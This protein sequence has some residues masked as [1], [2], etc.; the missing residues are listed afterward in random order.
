MQHQLQNQLRHLRAHQIIHSQQ[1]QIHHLLVV[2]CQDHRGLEIIHLVLAAADHV[3]RQDQFVLVKAEEH[4][5]NYNLDNVHQC[6]VH[7]LVLFVQVLLHVLRK[8]IHVL[9]LVHQVQHVLVVHHLLI[10]HHQH[11]LPA[12]HLV[13]KVA[14]VHHNAVAQLAHLV[15]VAKEKVRAADKRVK[16]KDVK[17]LKIY[18]HHN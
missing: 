18:Q 7:V 2:Q 16:K 3:H 15:K 5:E 8:V 1:H 13:A 4:L 17:I 6:Q 10:V 9:Q 12:H 11:L 14:V